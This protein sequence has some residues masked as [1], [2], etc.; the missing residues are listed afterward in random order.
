MLIHGNSKYIGLADE[1]IHCAITSIPYWG[2]RDYGL[3]PQVWGGRADCDHEWSELGPAHHPGQVPDNKAVHDTNAT[4]QNAGSGQFCRHCGAW[5]GSLGLEPTPDLFVANV[6][7]IFREVWRVLRPDGTLW[8][9]IGDTYATGSNGRSAADTKAAGNDDRTFRDKPFNTAVGGLKPK[10][11]C[12]IPWRVAFALQ[13][14]GWWLR[15]DIIWAKPNPMP[16]SVT[17]RPTKSHEYLFLLTKS[18]RYF[19]DQE[20]TRENLADESRGRMERKQNLMDRTGA[21]TLG[22][23]I[24]DGVEQSHGYAGLALARNGKTGYN[25]AGRNRRSVWTI[26]TEPF[27]GA[28]YATFPTK[29]VEPCILAGTSAR[30][31]CPECGAPWERVIEST[32]ISTEQ[33]SNGNKAQSPAVFARGENQA[34]FGRAGDYH[35]TTTGWRPACSCGCADTV[36]AIVLDPFAGSGTVGQVARQLGRRF[37]GIDLNPSYL[38]IN[39][40]PRAERL[41]SQKAV[42]DLPLFSFSE[43]TR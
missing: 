19:Y 5:R 35:T 2:L 24:R 1:S 6:V 28:H 25:P 18:E 21:G 15:S 38:A 23:Q 16:E 20:A 8:L 39:A 4:G 27:P 12:G 30:G 42:D 33:L 17:D 32:K 37:V 26:A 41:T 3:E 40:L 10:D 11:L 29:L 14:D 7:A 13:A 36:P 31:C 43:S 9:N 34:K 22:K